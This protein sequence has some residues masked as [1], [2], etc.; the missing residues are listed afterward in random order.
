VSTQ[1]IAGD[2]LVSVIVPV[3]NGEQFVAR[4]LRSIAAQT[5]PAV[6][7]IVVDDGSTDAS[8]D[9]V[10]TFPAVRLISQAHGG[11]A[12]AR[13]TGVA[14]STGTLVAFLDQDDVWLP[15][16]LERQVAYLAADAE[17]DLVLVRQRPVVE[18]GASPMASQAPDRVYGDIGGVLP[19]TMLLRRETF[20]RLNGF[21]EE[22][23]GSD[24]ADLL[25]RADEA[26]RRIDVIDEVLMERHIHAQNQSRQL[27]VPE[28]LLGI[29]LRRV[30]ARLRDT[31]RSSGR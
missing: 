11:V 21:R 22:L 16:K 27:D 13:N 6:E 1:P 24:D 28:A 29:A 4:A 31:G 15:H 23:A 26:G 3:H 9:V 19:P 25:F 5:H 8:R 17:A 30:E 20:D 12:R 2:E 7:T 14:A 10:A 18:P